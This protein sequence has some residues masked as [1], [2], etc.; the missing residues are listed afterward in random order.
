MTLN[1]SWEQRLK[2]NG[3]DFV[4]FV[5]AAV[6]PGVVAKEYRCAVLF[7]K[8]LSKEYIRALRAG[9]KPK[10]REFGIFEQKMDSLAVKLAE[11]LEADGYESI[12]KLKF[13]SLPH[14]TVALRAGMGFIGKNNLLVTEEYGCGVTLGK[15]LTKAPF[16]VT[17]TAIREPQCGQCSVCVEQCPTQALYGKTWSVG[18]SRDEILVRKLC[19]LCLKCLVSCPYTARYAE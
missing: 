9:E 13:G 3:V 7:G 16:A 11:W 10:R 15:V 18:T 12:G 1:E 14:K 5:D 17:S 2:E 4:H 8:L 6:L 19:T